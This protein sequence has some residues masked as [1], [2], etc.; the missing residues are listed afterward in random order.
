[1]LQFGSTSGGYALQTL[2]TDG[3]LQQVALYQIMMPCLVLVH[4]GAPQYRRDVD[5]LV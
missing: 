3:H 1:M 5:M 4:F 2:L